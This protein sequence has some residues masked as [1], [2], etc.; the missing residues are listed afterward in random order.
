MADVPLGEG[1][2][3]LFADEQ[4]S[5]KW[6]RRVNSELDDS[7]H[8]QLVL[9]F[10]TARDGPIE[11]HG[12]EIN[13][14]LADSMLAYWLTP[15]P[16]Y[17]EPSDAMSAACRAALGI[18]AALAAFNDAHPRYER[19]MRLG[20]DWGPISSW[21]NPSSF[22]KDWRMEGAPIHAAERLES[23]NKMFGTKILVS[24]NIADRLSETE[25]F[26]PRLGTFIFLDESGDVT[27]DPITV[28]ELREASGMSDE[29]GAPQR[30]LEAALAHLRE[31]DW[32]AAIEGLALCASHA[33]T[34]DL[35]CRYLHWCRVSQD[36]RSSRWRGVVSV[37]IAGKGQVLDRYL[38]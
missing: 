1:R 18:H 33:A 24:G 27:V 5:K 26:A 11:Q 13:H 37:Q 4:G 36:E 38:Q 35:A 22:I 3:I 8:R 10:A 28:H 25:F 34:R 29:D 7:G 9:E 32:S 20:L 6:L 14:L 16:G 15:D 23:L 17:G 30:A 2:V 21:L 19:F 31:Q 12:G